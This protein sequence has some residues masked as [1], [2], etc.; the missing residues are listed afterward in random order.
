MV[1]WADELGIDLTV[2]HLEAFWHPVAQWDNDR[3]RRRGEDYLGVEATV[4]P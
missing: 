2:L 1:D 3:I 4:E